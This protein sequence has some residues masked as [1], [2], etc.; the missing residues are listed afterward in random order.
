MLSIL[1]SLIIIIDYNVQGMIING[2]RNGDDSNQISTTSMNNNSLKVSQSSSTSPLNDHTLFNI[3]HLLR[4]L[5]PK[6]LVKV[7]FFIN[8]IN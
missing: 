3:I 5:N 8:L 7:S 6:L 2:G 1:I 4:F